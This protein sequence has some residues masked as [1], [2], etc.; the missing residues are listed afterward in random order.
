MTWTVNDPRR[1]E[2]CIRQNLGHPRRGSEVSGPALI[3]GVITDD[4]RL[5]LEVC[6]SYEDGMDGKVARAKQ[7]M[8]TRV[9][10]KAKD[11]CMLA[12]FHVFVLGLHFMRRVQGKFDYLKDRRDLDKR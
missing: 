11:A 7:S 6:E 4:P 12:M 9:G 2:W 1:M 5:Y 10:D 3:D 8:T